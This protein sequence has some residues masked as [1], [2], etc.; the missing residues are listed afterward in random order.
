MV[1]LLILRFVDYQNW[2]DCVMARLNRYL[3]GL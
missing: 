3:V 2:W 1:E